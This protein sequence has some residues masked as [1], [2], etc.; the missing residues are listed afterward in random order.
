M[1]DE[2]SPLALQLH[3]EALDEAQAQAKRSEGE[4]EAHADS[5][6]PVAFKVEHNVLLRLLPTIYARS[7]MRFARRYADGL[8]AQLS[9]ATKLD[10][11]ERRASRHA[12]H[13]SKLED[14]VK[15]LE[16]KGK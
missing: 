3:K 4:V 11:L 15:S 7:A 9:V 13:L 10:S 2:P 6:H 12:D 1:N 5:K 14:R 16:T 8:L